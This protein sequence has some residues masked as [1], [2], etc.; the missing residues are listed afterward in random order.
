MTSERV[1]EPDGPELGAKAPVDDR[2]EQG[3]APDERRER[4]S[5]ARLLVAVVAAVIAGVGIAIGFADRWNAGPV[6]QRIPT[7]GLVFFGVFFVVGGLLYLIP[8][9]FRLTTERPTWP[10]KP[11]FGSR[12][13]NSAREWQRKLGELQDLLVS[14]DSRRREQIRR[15][16]RPYQLRNA[17]VTMSVGVTLLAYAALR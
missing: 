11:L 8:Q 10:T 4:S 1:S 16:P 17:A 7:G 15:N 5:T 9:V 6:S 12:P 13:G 2:E 14:R 3:V